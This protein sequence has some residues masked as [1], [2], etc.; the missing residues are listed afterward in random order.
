MPKGKSREI[1]K[2]K[3]NVTLANAAKRIPHDSPPGLSDTGSLSADLR[4]GVC[5][6]GTIQP[7]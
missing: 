3:S 5:H 6:L 7:S 2:A 4:I 1:Q